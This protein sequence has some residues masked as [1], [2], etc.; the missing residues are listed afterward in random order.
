MTVNLALLRNLLQRY[1]SREE[2]KDICLDHEQEF[3]EADGLVAFDAS[4]KTVADGLIEYAYNR[5]YELTLLAWFKEKRPIKYNLHKTELKSDRLPLLTGA[6]TKELRKHVG[7]LSAY[8]DLFDQME[9]SLK[10]YRNFEEAIDPWQDAKKRES[11]T[12]PEFRSAATRVR[13]TF[14]GF[15][16]CVRKYL[17]RFD[18]LKARFSDQ[19]KPHSIGGRTGEL[20]ESHES[21]QGLLDTLLETC[22]QL[23][24]NSYEL[25][26]WKQRALDDIS[27]LRTEAGRMVSP[28]QEIRSSLYVFIVDIVGDLSSLLKL[29]KEGKKQ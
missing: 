17:E 8:S 5:G 9:K 25:E 12:E 11:W 24:G 26:R 27:N 16:R 7:R 1:F 22:S 3:K 13:T 4:K 21:A 28:V 18:G 2:L 6:E 23:T 10:A 19:E 29:D 15:N 14:K 20:S